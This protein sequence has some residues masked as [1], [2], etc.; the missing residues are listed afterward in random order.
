LNK[1]SSKS[2]KRSKTINMSGTIG[3][4]RGMEKHKRA[5]GARGVEKSS[6]KSRAVGQA[7]GTHRNTMQKN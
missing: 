1:R 5:R 7:R 2:I 6:K 4:V 3:R